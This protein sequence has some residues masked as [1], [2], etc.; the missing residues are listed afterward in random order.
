MDRENF[1][2]CLFICTICRRSFTAIIKFYK[3]ID[4]LCTK[5]EAYCTVLDVWVARSGT[6]SSIKEDD[7]MKWATLVGAKDAVTLAWQNTFQLFIKSF[8]DMLGISM[9]LL[10]IH[11]SIKNLLMANTV[12]NLLYERQKEREKKGP[13]ENILYNWNTHLLVKRV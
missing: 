2:R 4:K 1:L 3:T 5:Q 7:E 8:W 11:I 6:N 10:S 12:K 13:N 9:Q